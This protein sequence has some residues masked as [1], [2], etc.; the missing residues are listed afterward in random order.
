MM[1]KYKPGMRIECDYYRFTVFFFRFCRKPANN[2]HMPEVHAIKNTYRCHRMAVGSK[3]GNLAVYSHG[4]QL[5]EVLYF[6]F[7]EKKF[8]NY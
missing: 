6:E 7:I 3:F 8:L 5:G 4:L 1:R 2:F